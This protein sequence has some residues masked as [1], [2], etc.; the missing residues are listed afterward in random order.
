MRVQHLF[1]FCWSRVRVQQTHKTIG[2]DGGGHQSKV[3]V[4]PWPCKKDSLS[5]RPVRYATRGHNAS[6]Q[7]FRSLLPPPFTSATDTAP[8][9]NR[10]LGVVSGWWEH[11][12]IG[13]SGSTREAKGTLAPGSCLG[14]ILRSYLGHDISYESGPS[15]HL[16]VRSPAWQLPTTGSLE[17]VR[18]AAA[19]R[20]SRCLLGPPGN[21]VESGPPF[22]LVSVG[23]SQPAQALRQDFQRHGHC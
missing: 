21:L 19:P 2:K 3:C 4:L 18:A 14:P 9:P 20:R 8:C 12:S 10:E 16:K 6:G 1:S 15:Q 11:V 23:V 13:R 17:T 7:R 5:D 22:V